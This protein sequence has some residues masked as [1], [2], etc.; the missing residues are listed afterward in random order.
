VGRYIQSDPI[1][2][3]GGNNTYVY[4]GNKP[5]DHI[6]PY[7]LAPGDS[8]KTIKAAGLA[9]LTDILGDS[10]IQNQEYA[11]VIY[12]NWDGTYSYTAPN[13]GSETTSDTGEAPFFHKEVADYHTHGG[14]DEGGL[15][16]CFSDQDINSN[17]AKGEPGF[18]GTPKL[19]IKRYDPN[20]NGTPW[21]GTVTV[22][23]KGVSQ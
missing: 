4:V 12:Q 21:M 6:D 17:N 15:A 9:A 3:W 10:V 14:D 11:G 1:G 23:Q 16:E 8:Y 13:P 7:G 22:L 20:P 19:A 18:L 2:L 5:L